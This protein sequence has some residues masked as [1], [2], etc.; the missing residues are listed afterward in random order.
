MIELT[1]ELVRLAGKPV[2]AERERWKRST[3]LLCIFDYCRPHK[4]LELFFLGFRER[5]A[6]QPGRVFSR[7]CLQRVSFPTTDSTI[8]VQMKCLGFE[9]QDLQIFFDGRDEVGDTD[10]RT[11]LCA[12]SRQFSKPA[13]SFH[14]EY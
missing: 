3:Y 7:V 9:F 11:A 6:A 10:Q 12:F 13:G 4:R 2:K 14:Y 5:D 1:D 8:A